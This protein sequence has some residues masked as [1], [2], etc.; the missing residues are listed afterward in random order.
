MEEWMSAAAEQSAVSAHTNTSACSWGCTQNGK[1][2]HQQFLLGKMVDTRAD[3][4]KIKR[5]LI[6][7]NTGLVSSF[8]ICM[9]RICDQ[10]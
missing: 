2:I 6:V 7:R 4:L 10:S 8:S 9:M 5:S 3:T 1:N